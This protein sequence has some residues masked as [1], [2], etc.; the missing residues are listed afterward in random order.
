M[1]S[2][3][4]DAAVA[5]AL[6]LAACA[7]PG[8][9]KTTARVA[10]PETF[11]SERSLADAPVGQPPRAEWWKQYGDTQLDALVAEALAGHPSLDVARARI[12]Q[13][14]AAAA[15]AHAA[16]LPNVDASLA[17]SRQR[18][19]EHALVPPPFGG[20]WLWQNQA[21]L[22]FSY[23]FDFWGK[24]RN[25]YEAAL[26]QVRAAE[27]DVQAAALVLETALARAYLQLDA[28]FVRREL[29]DAALDVREQVL[30]ITRQRFAAGLDSEVELRQAEYAVPRARDEQL[31]ADEAIAVA[32][33]QVAA[34]AGQGPDRGL[35][36]ARPHVQAPMLALP[37]HLPA[38][39]LG[40]RPDIVAQRLRI[41]AAAHGIAVARAAFYPNVDLTGFVGLSAIDFT[42]FL[43]YGSRVAGVGPA[44]TL[45]IFDR[46][47]LRANL[48]ARD[49]DWDLAVGQYNQSLVDA[50][51]D[52]IDQLAT[53]R[54]LDARE[55]QERLALEAAERA[56]TLAVERYRS[57]IGN[58]LQ[59][60]ATEEPLLAQRTALAALRARRLDAGVALIRALGGGYD[61]PAAATAA[62]P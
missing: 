42:H 46:G 56:H 51:R 39:L 10:T 6:L 38:D 37:S 55:T 61:Q 25:A 13:A 4:R 29:A 31:A 41:E 57:G 35:A 34:L 28:A 24:N 2:R 11:R 54:S 21:M 40:R 17:S 27:I 12:A 22:D 53:L 8:G 49:A 18:L 15:A 20:R 45:P 50:L 60:L 58:Y 5:A 23:T 33:D 44:L 47:T 52:V 62:L 32:R 1:R 7:D 9:L 43:E 59:V 30:G 36:L 14:E 19:S 48:A 3:A 26:G 16:L